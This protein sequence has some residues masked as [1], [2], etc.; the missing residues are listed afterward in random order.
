MIAPRA[1][2]VSAK[3]I[4]CSVS[5][6]RTETALVERMIGMSRP[7]S[8]SEANADPSTENSAK[9]S[10]NAGE[11]ESAFPLAQKL[12]SSIRGDYSHARF[13]V[14]TVSRRL[15]ATS[16]SPR[17]LSTASSRLSPAIPR[18]SGAELVRQTPTLL[19]DGGV[20]R[21]YEHLGTMGSP[22]AHSATPRFF[23]SPR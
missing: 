7:H 5:R 2:I 17:G 22:W 13:R 12:R 23:S 9:V 20:Y 3:R 11:I 1:T 15:G 16:D 21:R 4:V 8:H 19:S 14:W 10:G 6:L 18:A